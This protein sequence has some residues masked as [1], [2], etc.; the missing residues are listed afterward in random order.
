M[1]DSCHIST[2]ANELV[3]T[4]VWGI[5][6]QNRINSSDFVDHVLAPAAGLEPAT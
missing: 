6:N 4:S 5:K 2:I 3:S 1:S